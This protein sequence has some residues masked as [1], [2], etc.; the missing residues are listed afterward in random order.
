M[1]ISNTNVTFKYE[2]HLFLQQTARRSYINLECSHFINT[3]LEA[4]PHPIFGKYGVMK[5]L[6]EEE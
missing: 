4:T 6:E 3:D 5:V 1:L 2:C